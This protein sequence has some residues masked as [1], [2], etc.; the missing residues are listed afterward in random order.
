MAVP[1]WIGKGEGD[2]VKT[3]KEASS[4]SAEQRLVSHKTKGLKM[5]ML[6]KARML[7]K[8]T[9]SLAATRHWGV[10]D[11][12]TLEWLITEVEQWQQKYHD[13]C[14]VQLDEFRKLGMK[15]AIEE[16]VYFVSD[17]LFDPV[18]ANKIEEHF[19]GPGK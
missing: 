1:E 11:Q 16:A 3:L 9:E 5:G 17:E 15:E 13:R 4:E 7:A 12:E 2:M 8:H 10:D 19:Y 18:T 6:A 14:E